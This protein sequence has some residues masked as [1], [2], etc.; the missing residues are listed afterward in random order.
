[1]ANARNKS[2]RLSAALLSLVMV[3][4]VL[5]GIS[6]TA[7]ALDW[8]E[9]GTDQATVT[10]DNTD[11]EAAIEAVI[12][13]LLT[14][15]D[16]S[17]KNG[18]LKKF[19]YVNVTGGKTN[20]SE[21]IKLE[22]PED[23]MVSW[24]ARLEGAVNTEALV[25]L[26]GGPGEFMVLGGT[27][28]NTGVNSALNG[29]NQCYV[30]L[31]GGTI[32]AT[33]AVAVTGRYI[34]AFMDN[35][36]VSVNTD[37][38]NPA[39]KVTGEGGVLVASGAGS[40][41]TVNGDVVFVSSGQISS[42]GGSEINVTGSVTF[43]EDD[44]ILYSYGTD[45]LITITGDVTLNGED[46]G[47][48]SWD[49]DSLVTITGDVAFNGKNAT[50][51]AIGGGEVKV[52]GEVTFKDVYSGVDALDVD[53][54]ITI[55]GGVVFEEKYS[56][57]FALNSGEISVSGNVTFK[58]ERSVIYAWDIDSLVTIIGDVT[59]KELLSSINASNSSNVN[60]TG[61]VTF[62]GMSSGVYS[63][64][65]NSLV[66]I[67]GDVTFNET[68]AEILA[69][70]SGK[71]DV[72]GSVTAKKNDAEQNFI[73]V[74]EFS[75]VTIGG[76]VS[77]P[78]VGINAWDGG[79]FT[80]SGNVT[81]LGVFGVECYN[82]AN[83]FIRGTL[84]VKDNEKYICFYDEDASEVVFIPK[85]PYPPKKTITSVTYYEYVCYDATAAA[86]AYVYIKVPAPPPPPP[87]STEIGAPAVPGSS[88]PEGSF[89]NGNDSHT[90]G[91]G[92]D[93]VYIADKEFAQFSFVQ[94]DGTTLTKD[95]QY[96]AE[97]ESTKI[98]L[99]A[100][101][102]DTLAE[103]AHT[104]TVGF[105]DSSSVSAQFTIT[106]G[107]ATPPEVPEVPFPFMDVPE[108]AWYYNDV[109]VAWEMGLV[110]GTSLTTYSPSKDLTYA[111]A[112]KLAACM[113]Q[114]YTTG[115][116]TLANGSPWYQSYVDYA[117]ANG[118]I[119]KDYEWK[120]PATRMGYMEIFANALPEEAYEAINEI[121]DDAIPDVPMTHPLADEIYKL[122]R[123][124]IVQGDNGHN[125][126][127]DTL[128]KR[129][130]VAAIL[131][132]MMVPEARIEFGI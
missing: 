39:I 104:L 110:N 31:A 13:D 124:G 27:I 98:T 12:N 28:R 62:G 26:S 9:T 112:V 2:K 43:D 35:S 108:T 66:T 50:L 101:Y 45:S 57:L 131:A 130:E 56:E 52:A 23:S 114:L 77:T 103:G 72:T 51:G 122:Y 95:T 120:A 44:S 7:T 25:E 63:R 65:I 75:E 40:A 83:V 18:D 107:S 92:A 115:E 117:K 61:G 132:R 116:V 53:S 38:L 70:I 78:G 86:P 30:S 14:G 48:C 20:A 67:I 118:I 81:A 10:I 64:G 87:P 41:L 90:I 82:G 37:S 29:G 49:I 105:K 123:A 74:G 11:S 4:S 54:L 32:S 100:D 111:E 71:I 113:H 58:G 127:P 17:G 8:V 68:R 46:S 76:D 36:N 94:V 3:L 125:C 119:S 55:V 33:S 79:K 129:S 99:L 106:A 109:K 1:M 89:L 73:M 84:S 59:F 22:I 42:T 60:V 85:E 24:Q 91:S 88:F 69:D 34:V 121:E 19:V 80:A 6:P 96:K 15:S 16:V 21:G 97:G 47:V 128:I 126:N 5:A 102:L 93:L